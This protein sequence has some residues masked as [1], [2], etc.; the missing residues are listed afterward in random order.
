MSPESRRTKPTAGKRRQNA[1]TAAA[2]AI[3]KREGVTYHQALDLADSNHKQDKDTSVGTIVWDTDVLKR[4]ATALDDAESALRVHATTSTQVRAGAD[5]AAWLA[6]SVRNWATA[7][8]N[9]NAAHAS[10]V[11]PKKL[12]KT[13]TPSPT[14]AP[15]LPNDDG[16]PAFPTKPPS[17]DH[18]PALQ[19]AAANLHAAV[20]ILS[21]CEGPAIAALQKQL[22]RL[23]SWCT[24]P[25][26]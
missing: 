15:R 16:P 7:V 26:Q 6:A 14:Q 9:L 19:K 8:V 12:K 20:N 17:G 3:Q 10:V 2:R 24:Q 23:Q 25:A 4:C 11:D 22:L 18:L 21:G 1:R 5:F 13:R